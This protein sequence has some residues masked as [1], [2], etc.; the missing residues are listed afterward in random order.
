M[1]SEKCY[2]LGVFLFEWK[3]RQSLADHYLND[4][5]VNGPLH[6]K[7]NQVGTPLN[8]E[9]QIPALILQ[10]LSGRGIHSIDECER[11]VAPKLNSLS[12]PLSLLNMSRAVER[13]VIA[14]Q[15]Q[16]SICIYGDFDL[17]GTSGVALLKSGLSSLG[18]EKI[19]FYQPKRLSEGYGLHAKAVEKIASE[20]SLIVTVDVGITALEAAKKASELEVDL[21]ITDHHLPGEELPKAHAVVNPNQNDCNSGLGHLSGVGVGFFLL[22]ALRRRLRELKLGNEFDPKELLDCFVIGTLTDLVP[23]EKENRVLV[24]HGLVQLEKTKR[25]GLKR[26]LKELGM[27]GRPLNSQDVA[28]RFAPKINALSRMEKE[29]RAIDLFLVEE[30]DKAKELVKEVMACNQERISLQASAEEKALQQFKSQTGDSSS[31]IWTADESFHRGV[32]GLVATK[33]AKSCVLPAFIGSIGENGEEIVG[34]ARLPDH[35]SESLLEAL[36]HC[37]KYLVKFGGHRA[38]AGFELKVKDQENFKHA[39]SEFWDTKLE[40]EVLKKSS[41]GS[42][43][44]FYDGKGR[45]SDISDYFMKWYEGIGPFGTGFEVPVYLFSRAEILSV[46]K[47][48]GGHLKLKIKQ[49]G[50]SGTREALWFSPSG[51]NPLSSE[52]RLQENIVDIFAEPQWNYFAGRKTIQLLVRD[53]RPSLNQ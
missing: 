2:C 15:K 48:K 41:E 30:D 50:V 40:G 6:S 10:T 23:L 52:A 35:S 11:L 5:K 26:L 42:P 20:S 18:F 7:N 9:Y 45:L 16:E 14:L 4:S 13:L 32:I 19:S 33:L 24:K 47:L 29:V 37:Q 25:P 49:Y 1:D 3:E 34:S 21:I 17:D 8:S 27:H 22:L 38:A 51:E 12:D 43:I 44:S 36:E 28:I 31:V 39:L 46:R 53:I